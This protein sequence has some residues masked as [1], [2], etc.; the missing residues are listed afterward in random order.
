VSDSEYLARQYEQRIAALT[1]VR[2]RLECLVSDSLSVSHIDRIVFRV[3]D[4]SSFV[5]KAL[6]TK[7]DGTRKYDAPFRQIE[8]QV[9]GRVIVFF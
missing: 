9:A 7:D 2:E 1:H 6:K 8:D 3:K 5:T 4:T